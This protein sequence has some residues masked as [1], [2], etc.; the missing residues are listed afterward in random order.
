MARL[1][2]N[3]FETNST[4]S[5]ING[6]D[7]VTNI[8]FGTTHVRTGSRAGQITSLAS[9]TPRGVNKKWQAATAGDNYLRV[10]V[11]VV[12]LP[13]A[14]NSIINFSASTSLAASVRSS[15][16]ISSTGT[17]QLFNSVP[18]QVG[19]DSAV[20]NDSAWHMVELRMNTIP[21]SGSRVLEARLDGSVFATSSVQTLGGTPSS[22][23]LGGNLAS[24]AQTVG[25]WWFDDVALNDATGSFQTG[26]PGSGGIL[27][28]YPNAAGDINGYLVQVGG[29][30]GSANNYTRVN[31]NPPDDATSYNASAVLNAQDLFIVDVSGVPTTATINTVLV[32]GR[33]AN[34]TGADATAAI[35]L[36][37]EKT[38]GGTIANSPAII[39]N[40]TS[41][42]TNGASSPRN[43]QLITYQDPDGV[44]WNPATWIPQI[45]YQETAANLDAI[46]VT[47]LW[48]SVDYTPTGATTTST[49]STSS[50]TSISTS[51]TS[52]SIS[53]SST[54]SSV[55]TST[56]STS[57]ST[58]TSS[59]SQST[60]ISSTSQSTSI[61]TSSTSSS[62]STSSTSSSTSFSTSS[63]SS[64][65][66]TSSTSSSI[67]TSST[68]G[69]ISTS[70]SFSTSSTSQSTST[71][72]SFTTST[73]STSSSISTSSTSSSTSIST[74]STSSS[75]SHST[76]STSASTSTS[77]STSST[78]QSTSTSIST[79]STSS[80][81]STSLSTSI[82][83]TSR[84]T[85][86][87][88]STSS[89]S[90]STSVSTSISS[91]SSSTSLSTTTS[92]PTTTS[93]SSTSSSI[94]TS[95][96]SSS[97]S[98]TALD[99]NMIPRALIRP[100]RFYGDT[101]NSAKMRIRQIK[102]RLR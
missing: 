43:Y 78:S 99:I 95:S 1:D 56:S 81:I 2:Q 65:V 4:T 101:V 11:F 66:S 37:I 86:T 31:Q 93:T 26:Y 91:T 39:P 84:S 102:L 50:S 22:F 51:S 100:D 34:I 32:G 79:S 72:Q 92:P 15:I 87:S 82:S 96:T 80:S 25:E 17:L 73:S 6:F 62:I 21:A 48:A 63:T 69:S 97:T 41:W 13:S 36:Q 71:T 35:K 55:S 68:S 61:S 70:T 7:T 19:S 94:S 24:E 18:A 75:T 58:S 23:S 89:T 76:S 54:S 40:S 98:T 60:S 52:S 77:L 29:T 28:L 57:N 44:N 38:S 8:V 3:G 16:K 20:I 74:S 47:A 83:S 53:T 5:N 30:A 49:S 85:S 9:G 12:T 46:G 33:W 27:Q 45:G 10:Y 59:T 14:A 64:S 67:S 90:S 42:N 88:F